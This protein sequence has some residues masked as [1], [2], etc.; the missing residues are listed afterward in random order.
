[1]QWLAFVCDQD[2]NRKELRQNLRFG[3]LT[4]VHDGKD[5]SDQVVKEHTP[6]AVSCDTIVA[7]E[8]IG[9]E[10]RLAFCDAGLLVELAFRCLQCALTKLYRAPYELWRLI[11]PIVR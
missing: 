6:V 8:G 10:H 9:A 1:M 3:T 11:R 4:G 7:H 5:L 2:P